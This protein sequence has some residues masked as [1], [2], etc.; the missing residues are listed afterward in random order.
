MTLGRSALVAGLVVLAQ[1]AGSVAVGP[2]VAAAAAAVTVAGKATDATSRS[3]LSGIT[4]RAYTGG[5]K[6]TCCTEVSRALTGKTGSY[7]LS[8]A[9]GTYRLLF[10]APE[11]SAYA[12]LWWGGSS[13]FASAKDLSLRS[14]RGGVNIALARR[15]APTTTTTVGGYTFRVTSTQLATAYIE[16]S[17]STSAATTL[18]ATV[19]ADVRRVEA[20]LGRTFASRPPIWAFATERSFVR[21]IGSIFGETVPDAGEF[22]GFFLSSADAVVLNHAQMSAGTTAVS[23]IRH[24]LTHALID[25]IIG[26]AGY[27]SLPVWLNE[28]SARLEEYTISGLRWF[29]LLEKYTSVSIAANDLLPALDEMAS[30]YLSAQEYAVSAQAVRLLRDDLGQAGL[31]RV[32]ELIGAGST[33]ESAYQAV[34]AAPFSGFAARYDDR[35]LDSAS[36]CAAANTCTRLVPGI[37]TAD[38]TP[39]GRGL[40]IVIYGFAPGSRITYSVVSSRAR[41]RTLSARVND[42]GVFATYLDTRWPKG[43]YRITA[44]G[45]AGKVELSVAKAS[46]AEVSAFVLQELVPTAID[47]RDVTAR[48]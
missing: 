5:A 41:T 24:E 4:V 30:G 18:L 3:G 26:P 31:V 27:A 32:L 29:E 43:T 33:F 15:T 13:E 45:T 7:R 11:G 40:E 1:L 44:N 6:S 20:D 39:A 37:A 42:V 14:S 16:S 10:D 47:L 46:G 8:V 2:S 21:G 35:V 38:D 19:D 28:G 36:T 22:D 34:A 25:E 17:I 48:R 23:V 9:A 12:D